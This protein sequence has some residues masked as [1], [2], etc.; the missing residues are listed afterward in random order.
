MLPPSSTPSD[1]LYNHA[2]TLLFLVVLAIMGWTCKM[3]LYPV[4]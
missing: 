4:E 1:L 2:G 3:L